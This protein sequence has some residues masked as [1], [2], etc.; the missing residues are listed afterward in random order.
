MSRVSSS[1][2]VLSRVYSSI[3]VI[4]ASLISHTL[5][6]FLFSSKS[7]I[8]ESKPDTITCLEI[9]SR[10]AEVSISLSALQTHC[11]CVYKRIKEEE[12]SLSLFVPRKEGSLKIIPTLLPTIVV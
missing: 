6:T 5:V 9:H 10:E 4:L 1:F 2:P 12:A 8:F 11:V 7:C 3:Y